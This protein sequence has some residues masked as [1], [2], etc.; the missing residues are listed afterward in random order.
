MPCYSPLKAFR[1]IEGDIVF[2]EDK[3]EVIESL[4]LACGQCIGC[5]ITRAKHWSIRCMHEA[6][7]YRDNCFITLTYNPVN[8][9]MMDI[10]LDDPP[11]RIATLR[12]RDFTL[13]MKKLRKRISPD[14]VRYF[15]CGEYGDQRSRP[16]FHALLFGFDFS[17][18]YLHQITRRGDR[19]YRSSTLEELWPYG[20]STIGAV[21]P[22]SAQYVARYIFKK[23]NGRDSRYHY[24][25]RVPE[26]IVMSRRPGIGRDWIDKYKSD[27]YPHDF[28]VCDDGKKFSPPRY[29]DSVLDDDE[30]EDIKVSRFM[31]AMEH[32]QDQT[33]ARLKARLECAER[34]SRLMRPLEGFNGD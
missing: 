26:Y 15:S 7:L 21:T 1:T 31:R 23:I 33:P 19:L 28:I 8:V 5:R 34:R 13:F 11:E 4:M 22:M 20:F 12:P 24:V 10:T 14:K 3:Y 6:S 27:V 17:D 18:K 32:A 2:N 30:K 25:G 29:Y 16:H 9:P